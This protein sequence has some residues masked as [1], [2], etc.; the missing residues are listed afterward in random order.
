VGG[1]AVAS[2]AADEGAQNGLTK[3]ILTT[4][5]VSLMKFAHFDR[6]R[7]AMLCGGSH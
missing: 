6:L 7:T 4:I 5:K 3:N 2:G 1:G